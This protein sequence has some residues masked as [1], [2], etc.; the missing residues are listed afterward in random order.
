MSFFSKMPPFSRRKALS[1]G[2][3]AAAVAA[4]NPIE[5]FTAPK[6]SG[7][8]KV[9]YFGGDY[10]HNGV[11]QEKYLRQTFSLTGWRILFAQASRF[12][13]PEVLADTDLFMMTRTGSEDAQGYSADGLVEHRPL[14]D[15]LMPP[16]TEQALFDNVRNRGMGFIAL[17]CTAG[18][19]ERPALMDFIGVKPLRSGAELQPVRFGDFDRDHPITQGFSEFEVDLDENLRKE[20]ADDT[21]TRLF[22]ATGVRDGNTYNGGWCL[23]RGNG[24]VVVLLAGH[25][26]SAW[27]HPQYRQLHWRA[28]HWAMKRDIP[29]FE[30]ES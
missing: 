16:E 22:T 5:A 24:R 26:N 3:A 9:V 27:S 8:T 23:V 13:T 15:M 7:E 11:G 29:P 17:H 10:I 2:I 19:P 14:P 20:I 18:I 25:T 21:A 4:H 6:K 30:M 1:A 28:A 12:I